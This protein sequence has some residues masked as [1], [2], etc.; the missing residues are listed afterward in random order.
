MNIV[1]KI[2]RSGL[3]CVIMRHFP[4]NV[5]KRGFK[6]VAENVFMFRAASTLKLKGFKIISY[7][8]IARNSPVNILSIEKMCVN[9]ISISMFFT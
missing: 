7:L 2:S 9:V 3:F 5:S 6:R 4:R 8:T 1:W